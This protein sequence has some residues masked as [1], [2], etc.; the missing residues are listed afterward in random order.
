MHIHL[1]LIAIMNTV[2]QN[3]VIGFSLNWQAYPGAHLIMLRW[4]DLNGDG[5]V[6]TGELSIEQVK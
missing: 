6:Q 1:L 5:L 4:R 2:H 3:N